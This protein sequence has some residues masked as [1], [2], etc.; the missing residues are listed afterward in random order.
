MKRKLQDI[1]ICL[2][3]SS[4]NF[5]ELFSEKGSTTVFT[6]I[7]MAS[8]MTLVIMLVTFSKMKG[9][10]G[11][12]DALLSLA[13]RSVLSEYCVPLKE[14]YGLMAINTSIR[15]IEDKMKF[16]IGENDGGLAVEEMYINIG[17]H[18]LF[19]TDNLEDAIADEAVFLIGKDLI[20]KNNNTNDNRED[21]VILK[22]Q[23]II[24]MLPSEGKAG[25]DFSL[26]EI[27]DAMKDIDTLF[28]NAKKSVAVNLYL[29]KVCN[30]HI[31]DDGESFF[32]NE[33]EYLISGEMS[34]SKNYSKM[35]SKL[36]LLRNVI[37]LSVIYSTPQLMQEVAAAASL[38]GLGT[39]LATVL[40]A[41]AWALLEAENDVRILEN[42]GKIPVIKTK[43]T[44]ATDIKSIIGGASGDYIDNKCETGL[45]YEDYLNVFLYFTDKET[46]L[47]RFMDLMQINIQGAYDE[48]F[49]IKLT[50]TGFAYDA[51]INGRK[52]SYD[53]MY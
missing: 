16:Y 51:K 32:K 42:G 31:S 43:E 37:N 47:R 5:K 17:G 13:G 24:S 14:R 3:K 35:K 38:T 21:D 26:A 45:D 1:K 33:A 15:D 9:E 48:N 36:R 50:Y 30:N 2:T 44:W 10:T 6:M 41:E 19:D 27:A 40:I 18:T 7:I 46:K 4:F 25:S 29:M 23:K 49:L 22:N 34:D 11:R 12:A 8:V 28:D 39:G 20:N 52:Y 53:E